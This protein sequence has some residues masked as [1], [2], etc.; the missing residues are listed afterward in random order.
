M[1]MGDKETAKR[2]NDLAR[3]KLQEMILKDLT[4]D[5]MVCKIEGWDYKLYINELKNLIDDL[6][7]RINGDS[8]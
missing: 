2:L 1:I 4:C 8:L 3:L 7:L 6:A 5:L